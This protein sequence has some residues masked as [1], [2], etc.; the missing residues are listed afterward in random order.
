HVKLRSAQP[1]AS[2]T[3]FPA[4]DGG[5]EVILDEPQFGVAPGQACVFYQG[6]RVLG[7]GWIAAAESRQAAA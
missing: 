6:D 7:G 5:A 3:A 4:A 1:V 2:A